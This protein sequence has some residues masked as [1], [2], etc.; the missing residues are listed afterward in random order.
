[1]I[2]YNITDKAEALYH[3]Q[4]AIDKVN[5]LLRTPET[6]EMIDNLVKVRK[7]LAYEI[8]RGE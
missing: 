5:V 1:M 4:K 8:F 2:D 7:E 6:I 3:T